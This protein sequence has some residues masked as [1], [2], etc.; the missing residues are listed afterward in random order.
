VLKVIV[1]GALALC[2][3][4]GPA[5]LASAAPSKSAS[6]ARWV[7]SFNEKVQLREGQDFHG[8]RVVHVDDALNLAAVEGD[9]HFLARAK[10]DTRV[11]FVED[12]PWQ[13]LLQLT[14]NDARYGE[15]YGPALIGGPVAWDTTLGSSSV[16][17]CVAD[18]GVR[19]THEDIAPVWGGGYDFVNN[20][21]DPADDHGHGTHASGIAAAALNN[22]LGIAG[23]ARATLK[24]AKVLDAAGSGSWSVVASGIRWCADQ[25]AASISLSLGGTAGS[26][27]LQSAVDY[28]WSH[29]SVVVA[30]A[31]NGACTN[32]VMYPAK[33]A[34]AIAVSC[35]YSNKALCSF[36][37]TGPE[38]DLAAP[39]SGILATYA[40]AD[41]A[42]VKM[43]GTSM[44][45]P[46]VAGLAALYKS[47]HPLASGAD[48]QAA[49]KAGARNV[50][51]P[52]DVQGAG[53][54]QG[55]TV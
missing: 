26:S 1:A 13:R 45:T 2:L 48:V 44:S 33:Y 9:G 29:G 16:I 35:V 23:V 3:L 14:P 30:A 31:G 20:D 42:Y 21:A 38:V 43:S 19:Y 49:L 11:R 50:G 12:D 55:T 39:G 5:M 28:A 6:P 24:H 40:S 7:V 41:N 51:L 15:Q 52:S 54:I 53:L 18:T 32:C 36:S 37:S 25:G 46:H 22:G 8:G 27:T 17:V 47:A 34:N 10:G 4:A